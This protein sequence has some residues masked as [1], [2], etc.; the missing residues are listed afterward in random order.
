MNKLLP[1]KDKI[2]FARG[3]FF[4]FILIFCFLGACPLFASEAGNG[5]SS[6][7]QIKTYKKHMES[8]YSLLSDPSITYYGIVPRATQSHKA[9]ELINPMAPSSYG[10]GR[11]MVSWN[12]GEGKPKGFIVAGIRFW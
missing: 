1:L 11:N 5:F 7:T 6:P 12:S 4:G 3:Y 9:W 2:V 8:K 10:Y